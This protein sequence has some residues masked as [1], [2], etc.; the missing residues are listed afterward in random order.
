MMRRGSCVLIPGSISPTIPLSTSRTPPPAV[1]LSHTARAKASLLSLTSTLTHCLHRLR[2]RLRS[3]PHPSPSPSPTPAPDTSAY[4]QWEGSE[5]QALHSAYTQRCTSLD[6]NSPSHLL[7]AGH[8][9]PISGADIP[10]P[11]VALW[12][13]L[14]PTLA[15]ALHCPLHTAFTEAEIFADQTRF[16]P[17]IEASHD[18]AAVRIEPAGPHPA[19]VLRQF[20]PKQ[21]AQ[22]ERVG[23]AVHGWL[24]RVDRE[25][26]G[27]YQNPETR[28][29]CGLGLL[30]SPVHCHGNAL[31]MKGMLDAME[32]NDREEWVKEV[33]YLA[34]VF[35][36]STHGARLSFV[37][38]CACLFVTKQFPSVLSRQQYLHFILYCGRMN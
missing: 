13:I 23:G 24:A 36:A 5:A 26:G 20:P 21:A 31:H 11:T 30:V 6:D 2:L 32:K 17:A 7:I 27:H 29:Q 28:G 34:S 3:L 25:A 1:H 37:D 12:S 18:P 35:D 14:C 9:I 22:V 38:V 10:P 33:T 4:G 15:A 8:L 16:S 19:T